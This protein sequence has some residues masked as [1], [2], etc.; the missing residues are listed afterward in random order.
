[1][2]SL[3]NK[4]VLVTGAA[5]GI[6]K[7]IA[8]A[9]RKQGYYVAYGYNNNIITDENC[10]S[11]QVDIASR[12]SIKKAIKKA[13]THF[14][15]HIS[16]LVNNAAIAQEKD[17]LT[18]SDDDWENMLN[19][20][21]KGAFSFS[22]EVIP[23]MIQ[24]KWGRIINITSIGGQWGGFNQV[25]YAASKAALISLTNSLAKI[26]SRDGINT[27]AISPGL[28]A[29]EMSKAELS[30]EAGK[31]KAK[32]IPMGRLGTSQEIADIALYLASEQSSYVTGQTIN[33]NGGMYFG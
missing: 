15:T 25:H 12:T 6:G 29:T 26:Y 14:N 24:N 19:V 30:S 21:L 2:Q 11:V 9:F 27:N 5:K 23:N 16:V 13:E 22:Q 31:E 8:D 1:M 20:N 7:A 17:F 3:T 18:I 32:N 4:L 10:F 28:V 33:A